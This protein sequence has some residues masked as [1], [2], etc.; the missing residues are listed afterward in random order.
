MTCHTAVG[1]NDDLAPGQT[2]I[3]YRATDHKVT[4]RIYMN[5]L[6]RAAFKPVTRQNRLQ[7]IFHHRFTQIRQGDIGIVLG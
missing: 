5:V 2:T 3:T 6:G 1:I 7:Y 4:R